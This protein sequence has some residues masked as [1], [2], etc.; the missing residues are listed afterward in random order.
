MNTIKFQRL[1]HRSALRLPIAAVLVS[2][3]LVPANAGQ[4]Q[5]IFKGSLQGSEIDIPEGTPPTTL[6]VDG[7]VTGVATHLGRYTYKYKVTVNLADGSATGMGHMIAANGDTLFFTI[8]GQGVPTDTPG[9]TSIVENNTVTGGTGRFNGAK[10]SFMVERLV[11]LA[12]GVTSGS[13]HG[14]VTPPGATH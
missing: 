5:V 1:L 9:I 10:G 4:Q 3:L 7:T 14:T 6:S 13:F 2:V 8:A 11:D 12:T